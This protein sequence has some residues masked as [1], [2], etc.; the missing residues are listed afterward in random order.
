MTNLPM[1][2]PS[3]GPWAYTEDERFACREEAARVL[4]EALSLPTFEAREMAL[5][6]AIL[7]RSPLVRVHVTSWLVVIVAGLARGPDQP[8]PAPADS[9]RPSSSSNAGAMAEVA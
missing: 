3:T 9:P 2:R 4:N 1:R 8:D 6:S 7:H 5:T